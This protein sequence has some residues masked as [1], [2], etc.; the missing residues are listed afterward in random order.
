LPNIAN[1]FVE[2][3]QQVFFTHDPLVV[4]LKA[5]QHPTG[6]GTDE[7]VIPT[8]IMIDRLG[9]CEG[10]EDPVAGGNGRDA[11]GFAE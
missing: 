3:V 8:R 2:L 11:A 7:Q 1:A 4:E 9:R 6:E 10:L 5:Y